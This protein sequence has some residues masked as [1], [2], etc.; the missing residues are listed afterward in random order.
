MQF[1]GSLEFGAAPNSNPP[2]QVIAGADHHRL[3]R[4]LPS[5]RLNAVV[6]APRRR[7]ARLG[8]R[9]RRPS[10]R[11]DSRAVVDVA[12]GHDVPGT[13]EQV[14]LGRLLGFA[15]IPVEFRTF[16]QYDTRDIGIPS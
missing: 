15:D 1:G 11:H 13:T 5:T 7:V 16:E 4:A 3:G 2:N 6:E 9:R 12:T 8:R 14:E 10:P